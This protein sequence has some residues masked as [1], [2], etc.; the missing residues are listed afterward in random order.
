VREDGPVSEEAMLR[1]LLAGYPDRV[2]RRRNEGARDGL[3]VGGIGAR[4]DDASVV[5]D[6]DLFAALDAV[7]LTGG[8]GRFVLVRLASL[9][10][11]EWLEGLF[12]GSVRE[13]DE[14]DFDDAT[15]RV[16]GRRRRLFLDLALDERETG[17]IDSGRAAEMLYSAAGRAPA[18]AVSLDPPLVRWL[19]RVRWLLGFRPDLADE[20]VVA[21]ALVPSA[22]PPNDAVAEAAGPLLPWIME[23]L[24]PLCAGRRSL[25]EL[26]EAPVQQA[27]YASLPGSVAAALASLAPER[28]SLPSGRAA[29][30]EYR[31]AD[32]PVLAARLQEFFGSTETPRIGGGRVPVLLHLLAPSLRP[33]QVTADLASFWSTVY[34]KIRV[35]LRRRYPRHAWPDDPLAA[36]PESGPRQRRT[37]EGP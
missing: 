37:R 1:C 23:R 11:R 3:M 13:E 35:E 17:N 31:P 32:P 6:G 36:A 8:S 14:V 25:A 19:A 5:R 12:P 29:R 22:P 27:L 9:V 26:R 24:R 15:G 10:R 20:F 30:L 4:L 7:P 33:V 18:G 21:G 28:V 16:V 2:V 34:P